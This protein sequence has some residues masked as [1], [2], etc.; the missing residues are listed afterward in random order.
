MPF[1]DALSTFTILTVGDGLVTLIPALLVSVAGGIVV[2]RATSDEAIG[3]QLGKQLFAKKRPLYIASGVML[4][5]VL[6]PGLPMIPFLLLS[7]AL[8]Y[9][10]SRIKD[11]KAAPAKEAEAAAAK[12]GMQEQLE[13]LL[14][15][16]EISVEVGYGLIP[17]VDHK[18]G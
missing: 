6:I 10:G 7:G 12:P 3:T 1:R 11:E 16:D 5:M 4:S 8:A 13:S 18:Q 17:L 14:K 15:L 9:M 2:T